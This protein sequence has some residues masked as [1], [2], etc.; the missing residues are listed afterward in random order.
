[1][2]E[3]KQVEKIMN[4]TDSN[5]SLSLS[6]IELATV[7]SFVSADSVI[8][9]PSDLLSSS[10]EQSERF[11]AGVDSLVSRHILIQQDG[12]YDG[13]PLLFLHAAVIAEAWVTITIES[14]DVSGSTVY[15]FASGR[16]TRLTQTADDNYDLIPL[17]SDQK[18]IDQ[19]QHQLQERPNSTVTIHRV[20]ADAS[21][22]VEELPI[23]QEH[24]PITIN[25]LQSI[26][27]E[28]SASL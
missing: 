26:F 18:L 28:F 4:T 27:A 22:V 14:D 20:H 5:L 8:G 2:L 12:T 15:Y 17:S 25:K 16:G 21:T 24:L 9:I 13:D 19:L 1:M 7:L 3:N 11:Q 23:D 6:P 10:Q